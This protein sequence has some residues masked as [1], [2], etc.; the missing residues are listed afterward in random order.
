[1]T[2]GE[3]VKRHLIPVI[4]ALLAAVLVV[5]AALA[6]DPKP[7]PPRH[8]KTG[9][10]HKGGGTSPTHPYVAI[11]VAT[12][13]ALSHHIRH[14]ADVIVSSTIPGATT[15][16]AGMTLKGFCRSLTPLTA[17]SGGRV[18]SAGLTSTTAGLSGNLSLHLRLGQG[19]LCY[20]LTVTSPTATVSVTSASLT[21]GSTTV[22]LTLPATASGASPLTL[23]NCMTISRTTVESLLKGSTPISASVATSAG[24]L[25]GTVS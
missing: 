10:C 23:T 1:L 16:P 9:V 22:A 3:N 2:K 5:S 21:Q 4:L 19:Q 12:K 13:A 15:L 17:R 14:P 11:T 18:M 6:K 8:T 25:T 7:S 24:T 20:S